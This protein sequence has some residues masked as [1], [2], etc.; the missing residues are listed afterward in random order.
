[1]FFVLAALREVHKYPVLLYFLFHALRRR[2][3]SY[4]FDESPLGKTSVFGGCGLCEERSDE[5]ISRCGTQIDEIASLPLV[6]RKDMP[7]RK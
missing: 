2:N 3:E 4:A 6:A 7:L 1:M 5:A